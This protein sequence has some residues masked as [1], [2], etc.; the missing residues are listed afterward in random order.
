MLD[1]PPVAL[2]VPGPGAPR[3]EWRRR[4]ARRYFEDDDPRQ[5]SGRS[6]GEVSLERDGM[7]A[8]EE[9]LASYNRESKE[10]LEG[11]LSSAE[12]GDNRDFYL[13]IH[14]LAEERHEPIYE[15]LN[16]VAVAGLGASLKHKARDQWVT[17]FPDPGESGG[18]RWQ[19]YAADG[20]HA[21]GTHKTLFDAAREAA[22]EGFTVPDGEAPDRLF[23][24]PSF[25]M[26]NRIAAVIQQMNCGQLQWADADAEVFKI[27]QEYLNRASSAPPTVAAVMPGPV[28]RM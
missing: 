9:S 26:G 4:Q 17:L 24:L 12:A 18:Y 22:E 15:A 14:A 21:H 5:V 19:M 8:F 7:D 13:H 1:G 20:F 16:Y 27:K 11:Y 10:R 28:Q 6:A 3:P 23:S 25:E 2:P